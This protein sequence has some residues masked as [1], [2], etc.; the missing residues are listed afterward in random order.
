MTGGGAGGTERRGPEEPL[1]RD[2]SDDSP[3]SA[4]ARDGAKMEVGPRG[5]VPK[6]QL[7][8]ACRAVGDDRL[9]AVAGVAGCCAGPPSSPARAS[10]I[11]TGGATKTEGSLAIGRSVPSSLL[12]LSRRTMATAAAF[13]APVRSPPSLL[14]RMRTT[15]PLNRLR[16]EGPGGGSSTASG[17][18]RMLKEACASA[19]C[20]GPSEAMTR[21][22]EGSI[23]TGA[24]KWDVNHMIA[25]VRKLVFPA[26]VG[27]D[28]TGQARLPAHA[29]PIDRQMSLLRRRPRPCPPKRAF[30]RSPS[31]CSERDAEQTTSVDS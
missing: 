18:R 7:R 20:P 3:S 2:G 15:V 8:A 30:V 1:L 28:R 27:T 5:A 21:S 26:E 4:D 23:K 16:S 19:P 31:A 12:P 6:S 10:P 24:T 29:P 11:A 25:V 17:V 14:F 13:C 22:P 9:V